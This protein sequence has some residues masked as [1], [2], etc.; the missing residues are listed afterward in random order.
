L[1]LSD[2]SQIDE[3]KELSEL[4]FFL[5]MSFKLTLVDDFLVKMDIATMAHGLEARSPFLDHVLIDWANSLPDG[6]KLK[7]WSTK[8][9]LRAIAKKYLPHEVVIGPKRGF[10]I[11]LFR[12]LKKDLRQFRDEMI[13]SRNTLISEIFNLDYLSQLVHGKIPMEPAAWAKRVWII[14]MLAVWDYYCN[15]LH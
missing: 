15:K 10:E 9:I 14:L 11:P 12:W 13:L 8:A 2:D 3:F 5:T 7:G 4:E 1:P 6:L